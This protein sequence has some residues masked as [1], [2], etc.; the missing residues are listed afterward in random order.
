MILAAGRGERMLPL[1]QETPKPLLTVGGKFLIDY[2]LNALV[3]AGIQ[4]IIIN[5]CYL[6]NQIINHIGTGKRYHLKITYTEENE[7]CLGT[8]GGILK[9]LPLLGANPFILL[10]ADIFT[11]F[12]ITV[13]PKNLNSLAHLILVDNPSFHPRGDF[14]LG[15]D[16]VIHL[17]GENRL[18][19][20]NIGVIDPNLFEDAPSEPFP[21]SLL[22]KK[23]IQEKKIT[24]EYYQGLWQNIGTP[25]QLYSLNE[26]IKC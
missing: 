16:G 7:G 14:S 24:G 8:G 12:P 18:T 25:E 3:K 20:A 6:G 15:K 22:L 5:V 21:L 26:L 9:A 2:H 1:T 10:S 19:Y 4:E 11:N 13:L 17:N 23:A